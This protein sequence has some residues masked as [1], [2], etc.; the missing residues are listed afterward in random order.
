MIQYVQSLLFTVLEI[1]Q[2]P[3][4][5]YDFEIAI[6]ECQFYPKKPTHILSYLW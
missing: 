2:L 3:N 6:G 4:Y 1:I 5:G